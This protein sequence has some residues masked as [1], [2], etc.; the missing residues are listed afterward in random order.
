VI[1]W[2]TFDLHYIILH[3]ITFDLQ[4][5]VQSVPITTKDFE[6]RSWR[7]VLDTLCD[8]ICQ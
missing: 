3:Y 8:K 5:L 1:V 4:L 6:P 7:G 2:F